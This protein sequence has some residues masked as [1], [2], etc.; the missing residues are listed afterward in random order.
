MDEVRIGV[1]GIGGMGG[2][3]C[4]YL[5]KGAVP[6]GRLTAVADASPERLAWA[7]SSLGD[8]KRFDTPE[9][10]I[11]SGEIDAV[12]IATPHYLHPPNFPWPKSLQGKARKPL[13]VIL[14]LLQIP[15]FHSKSRTNQQPPRQTPAR[16]P[17]I[18]P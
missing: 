12:L 17:R 10:M 3:H 2:N 1:A 16:P 13:Q 6:S 11:G 8:V 7:E 5:S 9:G 18:R 14:P 15:H 4:E